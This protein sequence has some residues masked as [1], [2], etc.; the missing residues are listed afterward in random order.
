[1]NKEYYLQNREKIIENTKRYYHTNRDKMRLKQ[2]EYHSNNKENIKLKKKEYYTNNKEKIKS[3]VKDYRKM[4]KIKIKNYNLKNNKHINYINKM[5]Y[6]KNKE[7]ILTTKKEEYFKN[8]EKYKTLSK[9]YYNKNIENYFLRS[10]KWR[11][12]NPN[13]PSQWRVKHPDYTTQY[14][15]D[16]YIKIRNKENERRKEF[17]L[18]LVGEK[19]YSETKLF[20]Y[21]F[22][23]FRDEEIIRHNRSVLN[24][25]E[26]DIYLPNRRLAFEY[27]GYQHYIYPNYFHKTREDFQS[28]QSRD[29][30]KDELCKK[31]NIQL[32][33]FKYNEELSL[34]LVLSKL[35]ANNNKFK[36][37]TEIKQYNL[38]N[39]ETNTNKV[40]LWSTQ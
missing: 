29:R 28:Q 34:Q 33:I 36:S 1:M 37:Q 10:K 40:E 26:L 8:F 22:S 11:N 23:L 12:N 6:I 13:Y 7:K 18:P 2:K 30:K 25:L 38:F 19:Y 31:L 20:I 16:Y 17:G 39:K 32:I 15:K 9:I 14:G 5:Y 4:N 21:L 27:Q 35:K 3:K 24:S